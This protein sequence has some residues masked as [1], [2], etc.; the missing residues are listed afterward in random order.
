[1][2]LGLQLFFKLVN[3]NSDRINFIIKTNEVT[4]K[5]DPKHMVKFEAYFKKILGTRI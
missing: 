3:Q 4:F 2:Y 1:M 5:Q